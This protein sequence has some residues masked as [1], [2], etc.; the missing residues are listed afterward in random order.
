M[1]AIQLS[2][3]GPATSDGQIGPIEAIGPTVLANNN[4]VNQCR[5]RLEHRQDGCAEP[6][7]RGQPVDLYLR[8]KQ[9]RSLRRHG[10]NRFRHS[11]HNGQIR[12]GDH[13][14]G[15]GHGQ[16]RHGHG[17]TGKLGRR[18]QRHHNG[19][20]TVNSSD[21][22]TITNTATVSGDQPDPNMAN[23]TST[24]VTQ[25]NQPIIQD[26]NTDLKITKYSTPSSVSVGSTLTYTIS[27]LNNS[28]ST[29][30]A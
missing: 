16:Q 21:T 28:L 4:F 11:A 17:S 24:V 29:P 14:P 5:S 25:V 15:D 8:H 18:G 7:Y 22:G 26:S 12:L 27:V 6:G 19:Y 13:Q 3:S 30:P 9:C 20:C 1:G 2:I 23:N 10:G